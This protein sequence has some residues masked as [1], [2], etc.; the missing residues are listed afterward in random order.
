MVHRQVA[1]DNIKIDE[2]DNAILCNF[3]LARFLNENEHSEEESS[4]PKNYLDSG[5]LLPEIA[6]NI[7][8]IG[9]VNT[10][11]ELVTDEITSEV[12]LSPEQ[13]CAADVLAFGEAMFEIIFGRPFN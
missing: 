8:I 12:S 3:E 11:N 13:Y 2:N 10:K 4:T 1:I 9:N 6:Y 5:N 7:I